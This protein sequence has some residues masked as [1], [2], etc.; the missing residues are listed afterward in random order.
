MAGYPYGTGYMP[1]YPQQ[2]YSYGTNYAYGTGYSPVVGPQQL[3]Y[4]S[5]TPSV[6]QQTGGIVCYP[7][8]GEEAANA[9]L[10]APNQSVWLIDM[11][12]G[13]FYI[14]TADSNGVPFPLRIFDYKE[15]MPKSE[16]SPQID[17][18]EYV[19]K[20]DLK[21]M[22]NDFKTSMRKE[23]KNARESSV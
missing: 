14:K 9:Y 10:V 21:Q 13:V 18:T 2:N 7:I 15:R 3:Q 20:S 4:T 16:E 23:Y 19:T 12:K 11:E 6:S 5:A 8:K 1:N 22:F 17:I